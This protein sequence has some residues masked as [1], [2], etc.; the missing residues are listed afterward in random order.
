M[1]A[2]LVIT[3]LP[4][5]FEMWWRKLKVIEIKEM[6]NLKKRNHVDLV[7]CVT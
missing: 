1:G 4:D 5:F 3:N 2:Y 6:A 7:N